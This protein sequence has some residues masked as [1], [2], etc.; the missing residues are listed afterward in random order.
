MA[1]IDIK[2]MYCV[3]VF[4][5][6]SDESVARGMFNQSRR[7]GH[8]IH[9]GRSKLGNELAGSCVP[10]SDVRV[11]ARPI[12]K[13]SPVGRVLML[14]NIYWIVNKVNRMKLGSVMIP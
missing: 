13:E 10:D 14:V 12:C 4:K 6:K 8:R 3:F 1:S 11:F 2:E 7:E 5:T 9:P